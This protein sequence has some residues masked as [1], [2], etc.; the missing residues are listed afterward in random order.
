MSP[1]THN[2]SMKFMLSMVR[3]FSPVQDNPNVFQTKLFFVVPRAAE[4][5]LPLVWP[6]LSDEIKKR[7]HLFGFNKD[8]WK[9]A[10]LKNVSPYQLD[11]RFGG[12]KKR[13]PFVP[14]SK[15]RGGSAESKLKRVTS[16]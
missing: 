1:T 3:P 14:L 11:P 6:F 8:E 10:I 2:I 13:T 4:S 7:V 5:L 9:A 15:P 12:T 16:R